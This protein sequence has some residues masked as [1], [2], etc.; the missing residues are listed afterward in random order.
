M[1]RTAG[2]VGMAVLALIGLTGHSPVVALIAGLLAAAVTA[3]LLWAFLPRH[4]L[5]RNRARD[6][7]LRL[8]LRLHP[9]RGH[10]SAFELWWRWG[11]L[12]AYRESR[13]TR[14]GRGLSRWQR[15]RH[16]ETHSLY[17][18]RAQY[19]QAARVPVQEHGAVVGPPR[20]FKSALLSRVIMAAPG[21]VISSSSKPDESP[22]DVGPARA[23]RSGV[24]VQPAGHRR[25]PVQCQMVAAARDAW[26]PRPRSGAAWRSR[27]PPLRTGA[28]DSAFWRREA[29][30]GLQGL[31][32]AAA[33][34]SRNMRQVG[35][36][37]GI[38]EETPEAVAVLEQA[39][40][41][42]VGRKAGRARRPGRE[43]R[44]DHPDRH[45]LGAV[46]PARPGAR[47]RGAARSG[48]GVRH[49]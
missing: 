36:W 8:R 29:G 28:E 1:I 39:E 10:A 17:V 2:I 9:G 33:L 34:A 42:R 16:P 35:R 19:R 48:S 27:T 25:Y 41:E 45:V 21:A 6:L 38:S 23:A 31:F 18:G 5:P 11:R 13:R 30:T 43:D 14:P 4:H 12:P 32:S 7:R 22:A 26:S 15:L 37:V 24:G 49:R 46:L 40:R 44:A 47:R 3:G 20:A